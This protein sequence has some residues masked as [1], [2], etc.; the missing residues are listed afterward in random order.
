[1]SE[2]FTV[3]DARPQDFEWILELAVEASTFTFNGVRSTPAECAQGIRAVFPELKR[4]VE[5]GQYRFLVA[6]E[7]DTGRP[8]G[9]LMLNLFDVDDLDRRQTFIQD[10]ATFPEFFGK[11]AQHLLYAEAVRITAELGVDFMGME[12]SAANPYY[13]T[14]LR[15]GCFL[16]SYRV[17]RPCT[18]AAYDKMKV[19]Q[20]HREALKAVRAKLGGLKERRQKSRARRQKG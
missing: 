20:E 15:N 8:A 17:I 11:G 19:A 13:E 5:R 4:W 10:A 18:P 3:V 14:A 1:V 16:E 12:F 6:L 9:Y 2:R 7:K